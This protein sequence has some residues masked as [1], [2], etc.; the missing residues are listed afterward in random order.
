MV[1]DA[2][3]TVTHSLL[4]LINHKAVLGP[5]EEADITNGLF[6]RNVNKI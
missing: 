6:C 1:A 2:V 3:H 5:Y 4:A